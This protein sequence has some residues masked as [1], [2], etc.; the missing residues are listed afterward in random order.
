MSS[1]PIHIWVP[2]MA[3]G[4]PAA[5]FA[6]DRVSMLRGALRRHDASPQVTEPTPRKRWAPISAAQPAEAVADDR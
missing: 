1:C 6:R 2:M 3:A 5:R 4:V